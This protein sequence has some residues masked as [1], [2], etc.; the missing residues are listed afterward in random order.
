MS[1]CVACNDVLS[2]IDIRNVYQD[3][4]EGDLCGVCRP[5]TENPDG[6]KD[7]EYQFEGLQ[8]GAS[9]IKRLDLF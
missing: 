3:G 6:V 8:E 9:T 7:S 4:S 1:R 2:F 5:I